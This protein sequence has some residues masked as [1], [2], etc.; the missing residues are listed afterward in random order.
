MRRTSSIDLF[1][2]KSRFNPRELVTLTH[3]RIVIERKESRPA[4]NKATI[5]ILSVGL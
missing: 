4:N 1:S 3:P 2:L 5:A